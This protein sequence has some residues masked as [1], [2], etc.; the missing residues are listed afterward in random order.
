MEKHVSSTFMHQLGWS[1]C[2][3]AGGLRIGPMTKGE[4]VNAGDAEQMD[5]YMLRAWVEL[6]VYMSTNFPSS[7]TKTAPEPYS[8]IQVKSLRDSLQTTINW[9]EYQPGES[10]LTSILTIQR[11]VHPPQCPLMRRPRSD[12]PRHLADDHQGIRPSDQL[13]CRKHA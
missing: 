13:R 6:G 10:E 11:D 3:D 1:C 7:K 8:F 2:E 4:R 9:D 5:R 12:Q